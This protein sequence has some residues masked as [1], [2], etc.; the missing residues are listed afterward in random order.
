MRHLLLLL[1]M[2]NLSSCAYVD[3]LID[4]YKQDEKEE[5]P[6]PEKKPD[7]DKYSTNMHHTNGACWHGNP[8][9]A[10][11]VL[12]PGQR[13]EGCAMGDKKMVK[14]GAQDKGRDVWTS[15]GYN[16]G[17]IICNI[18]GKKYRYKV[19]RNRLYFGGCNQ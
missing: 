2:F 19:I 18:K 1:I 6:V 15:Y 7:P 11:V 13:A 8:K 12:C 3:Q 17:D 16:V 14:H 5:T 9:N 4:N 10:C